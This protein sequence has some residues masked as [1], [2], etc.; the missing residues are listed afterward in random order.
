MILGY[1]GAA[2]CSHTAAKLLF[3]RIFRH[4][5]QR[6]IFNHTVLGWSVWI[7]LCFIAIAIAFVLAIAG[8]KSCQISSNVTDVSQYL[9]SRI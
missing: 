9:S 2:L 7:A 3:V 4:R 5:N 8:K 6:H 1:S